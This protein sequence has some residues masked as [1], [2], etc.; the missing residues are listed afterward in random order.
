MDHP[1]RVTVILSSGTGAARLF[2][3]HMD[4]A[5]QDAYAGGLDPSINSGLVLTFEHH[6]LYSD[7]SVTSSSRSVVVRP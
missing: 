4:E 5:S 6:L 2:N 1:L 3:G 7:F